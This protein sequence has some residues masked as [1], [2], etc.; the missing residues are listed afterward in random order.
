MD[1]ANKQQPK[2][3]TR[4]WRQYFSLTIRKR[5]QEFVAKGYVKDFSCDECQAK[6]TVITR[7]TSEFDV[8]ILNAPDS[9][10][11]DWD[12]DSFYCTCTTKTS[13]TYGKYPNL[14]RAYTCAHEAAVLLQWENQ[15]GPWKFRETE[16]EVAARLERE[17]IE[18]EMRREQERIE[19]EELSY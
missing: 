15:H 14:S 5:A 3:S 18:E 8:E 6:A 10:S 19:E 17:R 11:A 12:P 9:Y 1:N 13:C 2:E 4:E 7:G 16:E